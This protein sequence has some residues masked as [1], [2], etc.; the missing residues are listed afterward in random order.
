MPFQDQT[1][2]CKDC[3]KDFIW[4]ASEQEF[5]QQK[6]FQNVPQRCQ[7][8]R[9]AKKAAIRGARKIYQAVCADCGKDCEVPFEPRQDRPVYCNDCYAKHKGEQA[10]VSAQP[11]DVPVQPTEEVPEA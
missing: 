9:K 8:C 10:P 7:D 11:G 5:Y 2:K 4:T 6:G 3:G 1:L